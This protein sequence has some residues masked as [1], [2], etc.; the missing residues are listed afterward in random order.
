MNI[1]LPQLDH[2][3]RE[4]IRAEPMILKPETSELVGLHLLEDNRT[5]IGHIGRRGRQ[6]E[7]RERQM[8]LLGN[9]H[10]SNA[11]VSCML[12]LV[13]PGKTSSKQWEIDKLQIGDESC[14]SVS[15]TIG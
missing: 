12:P 10:S 7:L 9:Q 5:V 13:A 1:L 6:L 15:D 8:P 11:R 2:H 3:L 4:S 14:K